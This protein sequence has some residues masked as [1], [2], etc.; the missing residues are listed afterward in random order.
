MGLKK[1]IKNNFESLLVKIGF[2]TILNH[3]KTAIRK[4][5]MNMCIN[6]FINGI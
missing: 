2:K 4:R 6:I 1:N 3:L 5:V